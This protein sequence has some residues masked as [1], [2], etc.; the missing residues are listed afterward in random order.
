MKKF[1]HIFFLFFLLTLWYLSSFA[2]QPPRRQAI[3]D[4]LENLLSKSERSLPD[5]THI[6][7]LK[8]LCSDYKYTDPDKA[9]SYCRKCMTLLKQLDNQEEIATV[10]NMIGILYKNQGKYDEALDHYLKALKI[11]ET[12]D[13]KSGM[14]VSLDNIGEIYLKHEDYEKAIEYYLKGLK[15]REEIRDQKGIAGSLNNIGIAYY[16]QSDYDK[17]IDYFRRV[18]QF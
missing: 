6:K 4:S 18:L 12:L 16:Y 3:I 14:G 2:L 13:N 10:M 5:T 9:F 1:C 11:H 8:I 7:I 17:A 15:I